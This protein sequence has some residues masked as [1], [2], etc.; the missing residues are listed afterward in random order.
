MELDCEEASRLISRC[1][2]AELSDPDKNVLS[3]HLGRC[4]SCR[5][6]KRDQRKLF[7]AMKGMAGSSQPRAYSDHLR[8]C[9]RKAITRQQDETG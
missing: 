5:K 1:L 3:E 4:A 8:N 9:V 2:D 7:E 6:E